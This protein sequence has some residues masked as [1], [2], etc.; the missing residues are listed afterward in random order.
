LQRLA[1]SLSWQ[2]RLAFRPIDHGWLAVE[3]QAASCLRKIVECV[4]NFSTSDP[5]V[6]EAILEE[7]GHIQNARLLDHTFDSYYN[8][9]VVSFIGDEDSVLQA[10]LNSAI[11]AIALIDMNKA[12]TQVSC[13][14]NSQRPP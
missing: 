7:I 3:P 10:A 9:L 4:P 11:K 6:V 14:L 13:R 12:C 2:T 8:R 1:A 5:K